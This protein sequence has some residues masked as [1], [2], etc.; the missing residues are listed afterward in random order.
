MIA[1]M[2]CE[3]QYHLKGPRKIILYF[4]SQTMSYCV[5]KKKGEGGVNLTFVKQIF[6][7]IGTTAIPYFLTKQPLT[8]FKT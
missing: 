2:G 6:V 3:V 5:G 8:A 7:V 1:T 4:D